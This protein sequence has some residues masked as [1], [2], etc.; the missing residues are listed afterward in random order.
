M[1]RRPGR[2]WERTGEPPPVAVWTADQFVTFL[3][4]VT[5]DALFALW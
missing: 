2:E 5:D 1:D 3:N 4:T